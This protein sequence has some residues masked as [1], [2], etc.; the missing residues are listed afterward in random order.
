MPKMQA[1]NIA[2]TTLPAARAGPTINAAPK[3]AKKI[4]ITIKPKVTLDIIFN[5]IFKID[6]PLY[7]GL[8]SRQ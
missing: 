1:H 6:K 5:P 7:H 2:R 8:R 4:A 3:I